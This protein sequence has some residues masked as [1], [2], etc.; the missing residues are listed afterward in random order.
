MTTDNTP[1]KNSADARERT[2]LID[3]PL[4]L[5]SFRH[6]MRLVR[7]GG[8]VDPCYR[9]RAAQV[10]ALSPF[11]AVLRAA[12]RLFWNKR[13]RSV[14]ITQP[15]I[16]I[17]GHW[18][19]GTTHLHNLMCCDPQFG[20]VS[21][22]QA[23]GPE[24][25][26]LP[27]NPLQPVITWC[28]PTH[29]HMDRMPLGP[30]LPQ[31][32]E[33]AL[34]NLCS[35]SFYVGWYFPRRMN[36]LFRK[37]VLFEDISDSER[38]EWSDQY[39][40]VLKKATVRA[41]GRPL[42]LKNPV[43]TGRIPALLQLFPDAKFIHVYRDPYAVFKSTLNLH[44]ATLDMI[45]FQQIPDSEI[46]RNVLTFYRDMMLRYL[47]DRTLIPEG[48]L[49]EVRFEDLEREPIERMAA[50]YAELG[51]SGWDEALPHVT[52]HLKSQADYR[53]N[54]F[55]SDPGD[56][57]KVEQHWGF[58]LDA[59]GYRKPAFSAFPAQPSPAEEPA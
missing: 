27:L 2:C 58:A 1:S 41:N 10:S 32:E 23:L 31:E 5:T 21:T 19:T 12:E 36:E 54:H 47:E 4:T 57:E 13:A 17:L 51:L 53:K 16:F 59:W 25:C 46:E 52:R 48:N 24:S 14:A 35:S 50:I 3:H 6:W 18:R 45:A 28:A 30:S 7:A 38:L 43:N 49:A 42:V 55:P 20:F 34:C 44:R 29:R 26:L 40:D 33:F 39:L 8:G 22:F 9:W 56:S 11:G 15:P 37:Y